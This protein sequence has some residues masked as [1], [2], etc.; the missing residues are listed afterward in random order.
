MS[1]NINDTA[2][3]KS[4]TAENSNLQ[5]N[6]CN[7]HGLTGKHFPGKDC[8]AYGQKRYECGCLGHFGKMF[9]GMRHQRPP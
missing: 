3:N 8:P 4:S 2:T 5:D 7:F 1:V 9:L 6:Q